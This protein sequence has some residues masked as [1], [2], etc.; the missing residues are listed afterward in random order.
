V[1]PETGNLQVEEEESQLDHKL[2]AAEEAPQLGAAE[3][4]GHKRAAEEDP[5]RG[6]NKRAAPVIIVIDD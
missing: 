6:R 1:Q 3:E 4:V 2:G 5:E